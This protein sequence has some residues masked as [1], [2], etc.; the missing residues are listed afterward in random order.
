MRSQDN[1]D[2][3]EN[4]DHEVPEEIKKLRAKIES[5]KARGVRNKH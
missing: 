4:K 1:Q 3:R 2:S 5:E